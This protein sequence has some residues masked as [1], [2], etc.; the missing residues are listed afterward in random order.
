VPTFSRDKDKD[1]TGNKGYALTGRGKLMGK[2]LGVTPVPVVVGVVLPCSDH[3]SCNL[4]LDQ[5]I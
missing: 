3:I 1:R 5:L 4:L 2:N